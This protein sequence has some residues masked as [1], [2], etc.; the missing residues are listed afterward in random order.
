MTRRVPA[1]SSKHEGQ[2]N[3]SNQNSTLKRIAYISN[4]DFA[5]AERSLQERA[6]SCGSI[7]Q[8]CSQYD[9]IDALKVGHEKLF[10]DRP[11]GLEPTLI[12]IEISQQEE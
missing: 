3:K 4:R 5:S 2:H 9:R 12:A 11:T 10:D 1:R 7:R 6:A 8:S